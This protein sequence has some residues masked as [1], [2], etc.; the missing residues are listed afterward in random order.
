MYFRDR[1]HIESLSGLEND[2]GWNAHSDKR[3]ETTYLPQVNL[4]HQKL[5]LKGSWGTSPML[6]LSLRQLP[7]IAD[8]PSLH[9]QA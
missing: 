3:Q 8:V 2:I 1:T 5:M 7:S 6:D 9:D 4:W